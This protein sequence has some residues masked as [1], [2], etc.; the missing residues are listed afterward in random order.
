MYEN[1]KSKCYVAV[2]N[3]CCFEDDAISEVDG[4]DLILSAAVIFEINQFLEDT[5]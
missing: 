3:L 5:P 1:V 2:S 4:K